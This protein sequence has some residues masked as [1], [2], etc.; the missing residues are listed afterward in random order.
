AISEIAKLVPIVIADSG[1]DR[2]H[3]APIATTSIGG[4]PRQGNNGACILDTHGLTSLFACLFANCTAEPQPP[5]TALAERSR[6]VHC[7]LPLERQGGLN[8]P[9]ARPVRRPRGA[10]SCLSIHLP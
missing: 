3:I 10:L 6:D 9:C 7:L 8:S 2:V 1:S 4:C 5:P